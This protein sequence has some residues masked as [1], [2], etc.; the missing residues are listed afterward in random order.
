VSNEAATII[1]SA[2]A[3]AITLTGLI[4]TK[5]SKIS[6]FRQAWID[7]LRVDLAAYIAA[8]YVIQGKHVANVEA[9]TSRMSEL[10]ARIRLR[11]KHDD[12]ETKELLR[13]MNE[14]EELLRSAPDD[15]TFQQGTERL[16]EAGQRLLK[17][18]WERVKQGEEVYR[19][20]LTSAR[21]AFYLAASAIL[22][23]YIYRLIVGYAW[24]T[25]KMHL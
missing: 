6:E 20:L 12:P 14:L 18:E 22:A 21:W 3:A 10:D 25:L 9:L 23:W 4:V 17:N 15:K 8:S 19:R 7:G 13:S 11:F 2:I 5:E 1:A 16:R 24:P